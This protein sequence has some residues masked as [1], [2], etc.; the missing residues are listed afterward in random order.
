MD[1][2]DYGADAGGGSGDDDALGSL[3]QKLSSVTCT[4]PEELVSRCVP[5][6]ARFAR[7]ARTRLRA[8]TR[9]RFC[10]TQRL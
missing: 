10:T 1:E 7:A 9:S 5:F 6:A 3:L 4:E 8:R 2:D